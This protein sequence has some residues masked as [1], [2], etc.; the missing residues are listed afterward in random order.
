[1]KLHFLGAARQVTGSRYCLE[2]AGQLVMI[3]CGMFQERKFEPRNWDPSPITTLEIRSLL[4]THVHIDHCG[5]LPKLVREGYRGPIHTTRPSAAMLEI[6]LRDSAGIQEEDVR[7][8]K[9]RHAKEGRTSP[10]PYEPLYNEMDVD[11]TMPLVRE[12]DYAQ[13]IEAV[14]GVTARFFDAGHILGSAMIQ[15]DALEGTQRRRIVFSGDI[16]QHDKPI[17]RDPSFLKEAD[18]VVMESTYGNRNHERAGDVESQLARVISETAARG[19][20]V[21]IPTFAVERAQELIYYIGRLV[22]AGR[23][24]ALPVFLDSP[25]AVDVTAIYLRFHEYTD[26]AMRQMINSNQPPLKFPGLTMTRTADESKRINGL[27]QPCVIM[28]SSGMCNAGRIK[29]HLRNNIGRPQATILF[30]GHQGEGTLGRLILDGA[31]RVRIHGQEYQVRAKIEQIFGF[32]GHADHDGLMRWIS[33][34]QRRPR[35]VFLTH[36]EEEVALG[37]ATEIT[38]KLGFAV[39]VPQY[40]QAVEL[41]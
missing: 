4:L 38:A 19:G 37:L 2:V 39:E 17:I 40:Q 5:L 26:E 12:C 10:H 28:A 27:N 35:A 9:K 15:V 31:K 30:V 1:M 20:N 13:P 24:P 21:I 25:M 6:M 18:Y 23:I 41:L 33:H 36:G 7:Y 34:F 3:D 16:G 11:R 29:H 14:P 8:K 22:R 32:S